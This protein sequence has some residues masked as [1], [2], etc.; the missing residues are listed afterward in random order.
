MRP[1]IFSMILV[2]TGM[3]QATAQTMPNLPPTTY[4][5]PGT[6]CGMLTLCPK[7]TVSKDAG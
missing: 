1:F 2:L 6:F 3:A 5:E 7:V 4:P